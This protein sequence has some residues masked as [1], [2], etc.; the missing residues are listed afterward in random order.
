VDNAARTAEHLARMAE[1]RAALAVTVAAE[2]PAQARLVWEIGCG[3]GHFL[4][5]YAEA[6]PA[7]LCIGIDVILER[8]G[9]AIRKKVRARLTNLHF[10][11]A[12]AQMFLDVLPAG[13]ELA[14]IY[15]LFPDPWPKARHHKHRL[16]QPEFLGAIARRAG[17]GTRLYF[18]TDYDPYFTE[19]EAAVRAHPSW[20]VVDE[21]LPF[22][23]PTVFQARAPSFRTL[24]AAR[25]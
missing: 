9:R 16:L 17:L 4:A 12:D 18:R 24:V 11:R 21:P 7:E 2:T 19:V 22:E 23:V 13:T 20:Q 5:A 1:R 25:K 3:H 15:V 14:A 8:I 10:I 6:H